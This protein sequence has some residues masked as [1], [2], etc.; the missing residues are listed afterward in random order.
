LK[1]K[2]FA[3]RRIMIY[4]LPETIEGCRER[5]AVLEREGTK[6]LAAV[7]ECSYDDGIG[8]WLPSL[9]DLGQCVDS[10]LEENPHFVFDFDSHDE[11]VGSWAWDELLGALV[12]LDNQIK[13]FAEAVNE[14][15]AIKEQMA[16]IKE[17]V[18]SEGSA[19]GA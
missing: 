9:I 14:R 13:R 10:E 12:C 1:E 4:V 8:I 17:E 19:T 16:A 11:A 15:A 18:E 6:K 2:N 5:I 7:G 3:W